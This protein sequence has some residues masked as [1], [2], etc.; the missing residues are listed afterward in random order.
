M[1]ELWLVRHG[2]SI[3]NAGLPT[4]LPGDSGLTDVGRLQAMRTAEALPRAPDLIL[5]SAYA[6][7]VDT[8][9]PAMERFPLAP[10]ETAPVH[11]FTYLSPGKY[12][13]T[14]RAMRHPL[15]RD[16]WRRCDPLYRDGEGAETFAELA[17]R[18]EAFFARYVDSRDG[19][20]GLT[21]VYSHG[22]FIRAVLL[23]FFGGLTAD[24]DPLAMA[25]FRGFREAFPV[26]NASILRMTA[27]PDRRVGPF[28]VSHL[29]PEL[30]T[31]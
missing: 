2:Q 14:T 24:P 29:P 8:A 13:G 7:A 25:R 27:G 19:K 1:S 31:L 23:R 6:R 26:H 18:V 10:V 11:E 20:G 5:V 22:Q 12:A 17:A 16:F 30:R 4:G 28:E 3:S 21:V 9:R 15:I